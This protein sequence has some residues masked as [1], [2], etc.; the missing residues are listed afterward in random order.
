MSKLWLLN[1][2]LYSIYRSLNQLTFNINWNIMFELLTDEIELNFVIPV[3]V[4]NPTVTAIKVI[5]R[6]MLVQHHKHKT[7]NSTNMFYY[8]LQ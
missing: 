3:R 2:I 4:S 5:K 8:D 1:S 7:T 6:K